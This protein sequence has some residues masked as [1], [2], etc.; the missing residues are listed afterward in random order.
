MTHRQRILT[1]FRHGQP[2]KVPTHFI[3]IDDIRPFLER[4]GLKDRQELARHFDLGIRRVWPE[5]RKEMSAEDRDRLNTGL[6]DDFKPLSPFGT[7][8]G[9]ES[10]S[11]EAGFPHPF[12]GAQS[13]SDIE[14]FAWPNP[15][16]W[17]YSGIE[18]AIDGF[19]GE[20]AIM[21]GSWNPVFDQVLDF[22]SMDTALMNLHLRPDL[23]EAT[24]ERVTSFWYE[25]YTRYF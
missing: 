17:D 23:I 10:Y 11:A 13:V 20:Y 12:A 15:D 6:Y 22:F 19:H 9:G 4:L 7:S 18:A 16:D 2:D 24:V 8:G 25:V 3:N 5:Y 14:A 21:L 1:V